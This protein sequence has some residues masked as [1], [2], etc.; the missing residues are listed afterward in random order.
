MNVLAQRLQKG[1]RI[2]GDT[3]HSTHHIINTVEKCREL[4]NSL[5]DDVMALLLDSYEG[6]N[7]LEGDEDF[8]REMLELR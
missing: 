2:D 4:R 3:V 7:E 6:V 5:M 1:P 8:S